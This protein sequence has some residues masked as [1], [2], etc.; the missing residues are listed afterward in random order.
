MTRRPRAE[1]A[2]GLR[3][4]EAT[5]IRKGTRIIVKRTICVTGYALRRGMTTRVARVDRR[6][7]VAEVELPDGSGFVVPLDALREAKPI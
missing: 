1:G 5:M 2:A 6:A 7:G 4:Q 3:V